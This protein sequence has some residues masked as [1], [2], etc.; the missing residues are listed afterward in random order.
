MELLS[1]LVSLE[2]SRMK[3]DQ[4]VEESRGDAVAR[5]RLASDGA[6]R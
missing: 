2:A 5:E 6:I 3:G 4:V 1:F